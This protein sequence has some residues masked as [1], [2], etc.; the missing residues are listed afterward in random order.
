ME[1]HIVALGLCFTIIAI[2]TL[3][4]GPVK[5]INFFKASASVQ[6]LCKV[7]PAHKGLFGHY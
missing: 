1:G 7:R 6:H 4:V 2:F 5:L 3:I